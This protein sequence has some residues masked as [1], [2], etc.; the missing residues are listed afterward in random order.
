MDQSLSGKGSAAIYGM[1]GK[2][3]NTAL[4]DEFVAQFF[5]EVYSL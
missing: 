3:P 2:L 4:L 1:A 5:N